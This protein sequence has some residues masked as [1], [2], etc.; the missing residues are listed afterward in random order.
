MLSN[1]IAG[2]ALARS[3]DT[4][5]EAPAAM[6]PKLDAALVAVGMTLIVAAV[7]AFRLAVGAALIVFILAWAAA[8]AC[9]RL[10]P[11]GAVRAGAAAP[12]V[13]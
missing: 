7:L 11:S 12:P 6:P 2:P 10:V 13:A 8:D 4:R 5:R 9:R 3:A 1:Q